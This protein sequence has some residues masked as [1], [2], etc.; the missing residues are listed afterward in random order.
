MIFLADLPPPIHGMSNVNLDIY[1][2]FCNQG[3][4]IKLLN[5]A[6]SKKSKY[7]RSN[8]WP[9]LKAMQSINSMAKVFYLLAT[10][11]HSCLYRPINGGKGQIY[12]VAYLAIAK[13]F[14][15]EVFIHHHAT[16]Y[17]TNE[18]I[19]FKIL[20]K[21]SGRSVTHIVLGQSM[22]NALNSRFFVPSKKIII[23]SNCYFFESYPPPKSSPAFDRTLVIGHLSN[24]CIDKGIDTFALLCR[25]L[26]GSNFSFTAKIAGPFA[27]E[28]A[29]MIVMDLCK[30]YPNIN[31]LGPL[32]GEDK[33][34][35]FKNLNIFVLPSK[36]EAEPLV[37]YEA[38]QHGAFL[39]GG[40]VGCMEDVINNLGGYS[41][42]LDN[43]KNWITQTA[44]LISSE[45]QSICSI[46]SYRNRLDRLKALIAAAQK[47]MQHILKALKNAEA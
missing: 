13:I 12:D 31:Y 21:I 38:A 17:I 2:V 43:Q 1:E 33:K 39:I 15:A 26:S 24:L 28:H 6:P 42:S 25:E 46:E 5:T 4:T 20:L 40:T 35:F 30:D 37:L 23:L 41:S 47:N 18:K 27:D 29:E 44:K 19:L 7:F 36:N 16:S 9:F 34:K 10:K 22:A 45:H 14:N 32:Y 11:Q 8:W 3:H